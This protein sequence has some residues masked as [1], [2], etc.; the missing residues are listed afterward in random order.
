MAKRKEK[1]SAALL[2]FFGGWL[3]LHRFYLGQVGLGILYICFAPLAAMVSFIDGIIFLTQDEEKFDFKYNRGLLD[4]NFRDEN[5]DFDRRR[6][7]ERRRRQ[8]AEEM[9]SIRAEEMRLRKQNRN[10]PVGSPK[11]SPLKNVHKLDGIA[12]YKDF[13]FQGAIE[14]FKK[15][16]QVYYKDI[17]V[18]FNLAC[19]YSISEEA[20]N[21]LFHLDKAVEYGFV[22]F[23]RIKDHD[24]LAFLRI[25]PEFEQF[26]K[27]GY[28]LNKPEPK[29]EPKQEIKRII[30]E[31]NNLLDQ[32]KKLGE[33]RDKGLLT[34]E[35]FNVQ[36]Q[37]LLR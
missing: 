29:S 6:M 23:K 22:D 18:H 14:S 12:K 26:A 2:A 17:A 4:V 19:A 27:N 35:E 33:L 25:Q 16:L 30:P 7:E 9:A 15:S 13:D 36:K 34:D 21:A 37:R 31:S 24:A 28:R 11:K 1:T 3:G 32:L 8:K 20:E 5:A 10:K